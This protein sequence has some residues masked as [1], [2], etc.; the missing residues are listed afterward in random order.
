MKSQLKEGIPSVLRRQSCGTH[1]IAIHNNEQMA[2]HCNTPGSPSKFSSSPPVYANPVLWKEV[3]AAYQCSPFIYVHLAAGN[4]GPKRNQ[5]HTRDGVTLS[6]LAAISFGCFPVGS[7]NFQVSH[8]ATSMLLLYTLE[9]ISVY[10]G[11]NCLFCTQ[12]LLSL[13]SSRTLRT[14]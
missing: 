2:P 3:A 7:R 13:N 11:I 5:L 8:W 4:A 12:D 10:K 1:L 14:Q 9:H 6:A